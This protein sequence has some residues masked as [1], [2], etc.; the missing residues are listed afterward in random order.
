MSHEDHICPSNWTFVN[1]SVRACRRTTESPACDSAIFSVGGFEYS[2]V[3]GK[4]LA[5]QRGTPDAFDRSTNSEAR[6]SDHMW[7]VLPSLMAQWDPG[8][9]SGHLQLLCMSRNTHIMSQDITMPVQ[10]QSQ[11]ALWDSVF[12]WENYFYDT[13]NLGPGCSSTV[14]Y[15]DD[16]VVGWARVWPQQH[17]LQVENRPLWFCVQLDEV[18]R[19]DLELRICSDQNSYDED[20]L[21]SYVK[22]YVVT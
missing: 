16:P 1:T 10:Y 8:G 13:G 14:T 19:E 17:L 18:T 9:T 21:V 7:M 12:H 3:C 11:L 4:V 6:R 2:K 5:Y 15:T 22:M 20:V